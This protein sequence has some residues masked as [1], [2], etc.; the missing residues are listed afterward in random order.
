MKRAHMEIQKDEIS[1]NKNKFETCLDCN[2][3]Q[4]LSENKTCNLSV[5]FLP[6]CM[7]RVINFNDDAN[8]DIPINII[9]SKNECLSMKVHTTLTQDDIV[10]SKLIPWHTQDSDLIKK[11]KEKLGEE[12]SPK[13]IMDLLENRKMYL[14]PPRYLST[15]SQRGTREQGIPGRHTNAG[16]KSGNKT[17]RRWR[18]KGRAALRSQKWMVSPGLLIWCCPVAQVHQ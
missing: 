8:T 18:E 1:E 10:I 17:C 2:I 13:A 15:G 16:H 7:V 5:L 11:D 3:Y 4:V 14:P 9:H 12:K 6:G